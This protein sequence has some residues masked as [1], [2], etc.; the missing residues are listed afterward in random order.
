M[1]LPFPKFTSPNR[2]SLLMTYLANY[3]DDQHRLGQEVLL[4]TDYLSAS[5]RCLWYLQSSSW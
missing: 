3:L 4:P 2:L 5:L 1:S